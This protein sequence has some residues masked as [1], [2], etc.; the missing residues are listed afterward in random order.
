ME[1]AEKQLK[2]LQSKEGGEAVS[3]EAQDKTIAQ[4]TEELLTTRQQLRD[5]TFNLRK[6]IEA[7]QTRLTVINVAAVPA[8]IAMAALVIGFVRVRRRRRH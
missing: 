6:D 7:L 4:F 5:V 8:A 2:E 1:E 3:A